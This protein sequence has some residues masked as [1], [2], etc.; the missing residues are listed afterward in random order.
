[1][2]S[3]RLEVPGG[4]V[5]GGDDDTHEMPRGERRS[6]ICLEVGMGGGEGERGL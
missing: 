2:K 5:E 1:M 4:G 3:S 6:L